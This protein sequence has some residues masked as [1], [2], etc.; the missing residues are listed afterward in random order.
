MIAALLLA[1]ALTGTAPH[2]HHPVSTRSPAAQAAFDR[3]LFLLFAYNGDAAN[4]AFAQALQQDQHLA[5]AAWGEALANGTDL[6]TGLDPDRFD[7]A[8]EAAQRAVALEPYASPEER[9][10]IDAVAA[11]YAGTYADRDADEARYRSAMAALVTAYPLDDD[12]ATL[13]AEAIMEQLGTSRMWSADGGTPAPQTSQA[14]ALIN[15]VLARNPSH[16]MANHLC[17]HAYDYARDRTPALACADRVAKWT[18]EPAAEHLAHMP[19]HTYVETGRYE[20]AVAAAETAWRL[21]EESTVK[22][23]YGAHDAYV[24]WTAAMMLG[25]PRVA[26]AWAIRVGNEYGGSD[27]WATWARYGEWS[28]I[29]TSNA[30]NQFYAPL[31]RGWADVHFGIMDDARKMLALYGN[32]DTDYRWLLQAA[33]DEH[34]GRIDAAVDALNRAIA[35]QDREDQA[36]QLPV[37]PAGEVLGALYFHRQNYVQARGTFQA[38]LLRYPNDP[39][40]LYGLALAQRALGDAAGSQQTLKTFNAVWHLDTPPAGVG[41]TF[42]QSHGPPGQNA[43]AHR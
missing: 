25:D 14:L 1:A 4:N 24:G 42:F 37:F 20:Q 6:N 28:R 8:H 13:D 12:A 17:M 31:V 41:F 36:E 19:V 9:A 7:A 40:A 3:G 39:R 21:R 29:N 2:V 26:E 15:R 27:L 11:R 16:V 30:A 38:T 34:D 23:K 32:T 22:L 43:Q 18:M 35:Y 33:I 10:Y 5:M